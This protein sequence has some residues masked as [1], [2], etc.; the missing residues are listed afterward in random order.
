MRV[1]KVAR[2][3]ALISMVSI[4]AKGIWHAGKAVQEGRKM[5]FMDQSAPTAIVP[6]P[7]LSLPEG[8]AGPIMT[9]LSDGLKKKMAAVEKDIFDPKTGFVLSFG[10]EQDRKGL[11]KAIEG[12]EPLLGIMSLT[13]S[14]QV[15]DEGDAYLGEGVCAVPKGT[16]MSE[17]TLSDQTKFEASMRFLREHRTGQLH[18]LYKWRAF[19]FTRVKEEEEVQKK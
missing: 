19:P 12:E 16:K 14:D 18:Q 7:V 13:Q 1:L 15:V 10:L 4:G 17:K 9:P 11:V 6:P 2:T 3:L 5:P 8:V